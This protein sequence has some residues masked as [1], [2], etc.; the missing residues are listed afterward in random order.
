MGARIEETM[1]L[2]CA[3]W[4]N[5]AKLPRLQWMISLLGSQDGENGQLVRLEGFTHHV[6]SPARP[7]RSCEGVSAQD[8]DESQN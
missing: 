3:N 4:A 1:V 6:S 5:S 2:E 8:E 7:A